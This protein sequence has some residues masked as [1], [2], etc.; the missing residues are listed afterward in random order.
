MPYSK[1]KK[2]KNKGKY[3]A[4][5]GKMKGRMMS[6]AQMQAIEISKHKKRKMR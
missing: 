2:G 6:K 1:V 5:A 4:T 3:R